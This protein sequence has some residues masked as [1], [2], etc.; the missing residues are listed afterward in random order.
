MIYKG[1]E[2][3]KSIYYGN[4]K[5]KEVYKGNQLV[6]SDKPV[7]YWIHKD[8]GVTTPIGLNEP[9]I[10]G[11]TFNRPSWYIDALEIVV[12]EGIAV[13]NESFNGCDNL[14]IIRLPSTITTIGDL[15]F[16]QT[17]YLEGLYI[18]ATV[19]P[20]LSSNLGANIGHIGNVKIY[21]PATSVNAYKT[22]PVWSNFSSII[23]SM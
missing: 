12:P 10:S 5:I 17:P 14:K 20:F 16:N 22:A 2:K 23:L 9:F 19:P 7:G 13:L 6:Y 21:V 4:Q 3:I 18:K 1:N 15:T 8:T 11:T